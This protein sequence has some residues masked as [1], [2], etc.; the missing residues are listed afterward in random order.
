MSIHCTTCGAPLEE[1]QLDRGRGL[2]RCRHCDTVVELDLSQ[3]EPRRR[4]PHAR[5]PVTLP[6]HFDF[7]QRGEALVIRW[8]W[9]T[10]KTL[11]WA[12]FTLIWFLALGGY[13]AG[14]LGPG[15]SAE[16]GV[17]AGQLL[18]TVG[19]VAVGLVVAY[20]ALAG[21]LNTTTITASRDGLDVRHAPLPWPG[22]GTVSGV[23]QLYSK[24]RAH[25]GKHGRLSY[26]YE[27]HAISADG[28]RRKLV[29]RLVEAPQALWLE[30]TLEDHLGLRDRPV[31]GEIP[32]H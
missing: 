8:P 21:F 31:G 23:R 17:V 28:E 30:Q 16:A 26:S 4:D 24:E 1:A 12:G 7:E 10:L 32:R 29:S 15:G 14:V 22:G 6:E 5:T 19:H 11:L 25:R 13:W 27:L 3:P 20:L 9:F 2:A 18:F